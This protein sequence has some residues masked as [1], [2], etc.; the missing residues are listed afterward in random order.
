MPASISMPFIR[1]MRHRVKASTS[2]LRYGG[3]TT[4]FHV[5]T[6]RSSGMPRS[7]NGFIAIARSS[8]FSVESGCGAARQVPPS[9]ERASGCAELLLDRAGAAERALGTLVPVLRVVQIAFERV[10]DAVQP[11]RQRRRLLLHDLVCGLPVATVEQIERPGQRSVAR[12]HERDYEERP[13]SAGVL[14]SV[15]GCGG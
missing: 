5:R 11:R 2:C 7:S 10:D 8:P 4:C 12:A 14:P 13:G 1:M 3:S 15:G 6:C 9:A